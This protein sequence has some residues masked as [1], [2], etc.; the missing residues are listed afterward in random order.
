M[1]KIIKAV[2]TGRFCTC[3]R[4]FRWDTDDKLQFVN[5]DLPNNYT[6]DFANS[7]TGDS[8]P[9]LATSDTVQIPPEMFVP[10]SEIYA[11]VWI[12]DTNGGY[13]K[14]QA[15][16]P[17]D[18]RAQRS[19]TS[20]TPAQASAWDAAVEVLNAAASHGP[21]IQD[22]Y[23]YVWNSTAG[24]YVNT[25]VKA[26]GVDGT[27]GTDGKNGNI[28]WWTT[29]RPIASGDNAGIQ[30]RSLNGPDGLTPA[31][32]DYVFG[33]A[34]GK[35]GEPTTLYVI[36]TSTALVTMTALGSIVGPAGRDGADGAD[37]QDGV[38]GTTFTPSVSD[39]GVLSWEN[40]G[41]KENPESVDLVAAVL[42]AL[43]TWD[44]GS[45]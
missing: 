18:P 37:G 40:D 30:R 2:F 5:L 23:W 32:R 12:S 13:T 38:D 8:V 33:P 1:S 15:T 39:A 25:N 36:L 4:V 43:P 11:W 28:I 24:E 44:G 7:L 16:I 17:I 10:G 42:N 26:E 45:Y 3:K 27:D 31:A 21:T 29:A 22:G 20:P 34:V 35:E 19:G 6:V 9:V 41:G 14:C